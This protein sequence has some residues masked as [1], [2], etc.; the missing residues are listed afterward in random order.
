M[1]KTTLI[2]IILGII[3]ISNAQI[4]KKELKLTPEIEERVVAK[5]KNL[6]EKRYSDYGITDRSQLESSQYYIGNP[7]PMYHIANKKFKVMV[8]TWNVSHISDGDSLSLSFR[9]TWL[10]PVMSDEEPFLFGEI[11]F[12]DFRSDPQFIGV[13]KYANI[14]EHFHNYELKDSIIGYVDVDFSNSEMDYFIIRKENKDIFIKVYDEA[15]G[16]Y[17]K[18]EYS[19]SELINHLK[20]L[21]LLKKEAQMRYYAQIAK[22]R[23]LTITSEI[24]SAFISRLKDRSDENLSYLGIKNRAQLENL[25]LGKPI[26]WYAII[27]ENLLFAGGWMVPAISDGKSLFV[28]NLKLEEDGQYRW[29]GSSGAAWAEAIHNY[30]YKKLII[31][32]LGTN[33]GPCLI[34]QR[35]HE[36]IFVQVYDRAMREYL[37]NEYSFSEVLD[38]LKN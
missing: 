34:I 36:N 2:I 17:F 7:I 13:P 28:T 6:P 3:T 14:I 16:E 10:V 5:I 11:H 12:S 22:K 21:D 35:K 29:E 27:N 32:V 24:K 1:K 15:S 31:G 26:P 25:H 19:F 30:K 23:K 37:K 38:F 9:N 4:E 33:R 20:E 8:S 18:N